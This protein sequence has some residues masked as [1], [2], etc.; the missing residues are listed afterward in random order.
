MACVKKRRGRYVLDFYDQHGKRQRVT[1]K[2]DATKQEAWDEL[3]DKVAAVRKRVFVPVKSML[4]FSNVADEWLEQKK[5]NVRITTWEMFEGNINKH[6]SELA[7]LK[8]GL[9]D[10][11]A[12]EKWISRRQADGM[13]INTLRKLIVLVNQIMAYAVR[14]RYADH[15]PVTDAERPRDQGQEPDH[16]KISVLKPDEI[17]RLLEK[18]EGQKY[19]LLFRM[20]TFTGMRQG[21]L[22]GLKWSDIDWSNKQVHVQR[23]YTKGHFFDTKTRTS[24]RRIDLGPTLLLELKKWK[25][26]C[27][28]NDLGLVFPNK[29]G[30][31]MNYSNMMNRHFFPALIQ[32]GIA[33]K[34]ETR[35]DGKKRKRIIVVGAIRFHDLRHT[36]ASLMIHHG[37]NIKYIQTQ[38]GH[39]SPMVTLNVYAHLMNSTNQA[40][41]CRLEDAVFAANRSQKNRTGHKMVTIAKK[42][43]QLEPQPLL[44]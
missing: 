32:A 25:L 28:P 6:F 26:A 38:L 11:A 10:T 22:L 4:L 12:V 16:D 19:Q 17:Q 20:A 39:S 33:S 41:A 7:G 14:H 9:I 1:M 21:E 34:V 15:N 8:I 44:N 5:A 35:P 13:N 43:L 3:R 36:Y 30:Q 37:E 2:A 27:P 18:T 40:A 23:T 29:A 42:E 31:P 24:N